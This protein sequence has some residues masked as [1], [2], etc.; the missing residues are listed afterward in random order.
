MR[1]V[2]TGRNGQVA[3]A[4]RSLTDESAEIISLARPTLDLAQPA[5]IL[6]ALASAAPDVI[7]NAAAYTAVDQAENE[8]ELAFAVN[9]TG[10][11]TIAEAAEHLG[12]PLVHL[13]TDYVFDGSLGRPYIEADPTSPLGV[14]GCSKEAGEVAI[15]RSGLNYVILRTAWVY[16]PTGRNFLS[17]MLRLANERP[18]VRVV[19]DQFGA[20][21]YAMDVAL[22]AILVARRLVDDSDKAVRGIFHMTAAGQASWADFA[23]AIFA[24][25]AA[26]NGPAARVE[27]VSTDEY[28][29]PTRRPADARLDCSRF[30]A[31]FGWTLPHWRTHIAEAVEA[32]LKLDTTKEDERMLS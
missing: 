19:A 28:A 11:K 27:R 4:I 24:E 12:I 30:A 5:T 15:G 9:A 25:S 18:V 13:S 16:S 7:I 32:C 23:E 22:G 17:T 10:A 8:S 26:R 2:V 6:P 21:T 3:H 1:I 20:P 14:Y 29:S 31:A